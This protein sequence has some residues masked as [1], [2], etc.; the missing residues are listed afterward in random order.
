MASTRREFLRLAGAGAGALL[1]SK[2]VAGEED[3]D[4]PVE[5]LFEDV[6]EAMG[7]KGIHAERVAF[8]D[9]NGDGWPDIV[10]NQTEIYLNQH[11]KGF[12]RMEGD[13]VLA[14]P[15][16]PSV[17]QWGDLNND[18]RMDLFLGRNTNPA[19]PDFK[20]DGLRS[21]IWLADGKGSFVKKKHSGLE[22]FAESTV[23][24]IFLDYDSDGNLD[25]V[26]GNEFKDPNTGTAYPS[27]L[28]RGRGDGTFEDVTE[29]AGMLLVESVGNANSR[30]PTYGLAHTDW[31]NSGRQSI[32]FLTY[33]RQANRLWRNNGD[34]TFTDVAV[35]TAF[36][37][38]DIRNGKVLPGLPQV[39]PWMVHGN[40][41]DC[42]VADF[43]CDGYMDCF[44]GEIC[45]WWAGPSCDKSMLL[46]NR[47]PKHKYKFLRDP[48]RIFRRHDDP[49]WNE[50]DISVGWLDVDNDG[51]PDL[52]IGASNYPDQFL[53]L[54]HQE[55]GGRFTEWTDRLG[56]R[57][58]N[59]GGISFADFDRDGATDILVGTNNVN[60]SAEQASKHDLSIRL[61]RNLTPAKL[62]NHFL[63]IRLSGQAIGARATV[64]TGDH[65][66]T[67]E[68]YGGHG[69]AGHRDDSDLRFGLGK[70]RGANKVEIRWPDADNTTQVFKKVRGDRFYQLAKGEELEPVAL[71]TQ[72]S[73]K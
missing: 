56:F 34:G 5:P 19:S 39:P 3:D 31:N 33:G 30:R 40:N 47:G 43:N 44:L 60:L 20:D 68:V 53:L 18:G 41:F 59:A 52:V 7:L 42:A 13:R 21:E 37:G 2:H 45:H 54:Y 67:Q 58:V 62:G 10:V 71:G 61:Y 73:A 6:T 14:S 51:W 25:L 15:R 23:A 69:H 9:V 50:G 11:G 29:K 35:E 64:W 55:A 26:I 38:D 46:V 17:V 57:Y 8:V 27:R 24:A 16:R 1:L 49:Q 32:M 22:E 72:G 48:G 66:Q 4:E 65:R 12:V 70:A 63:N 36:D 28:L